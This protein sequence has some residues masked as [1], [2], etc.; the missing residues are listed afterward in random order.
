ML[1]NALTQTLMYVGGV[2]VLFIINIVID[3]K[4]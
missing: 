1:I 4:R 2:A 3:V